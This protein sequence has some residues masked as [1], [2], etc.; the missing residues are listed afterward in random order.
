MNKISKKI[1]SLV[2]MAAFALTLV[3]A[4]AFA[5]DGDSTYTVE[6][7]AY[8]KA[9]VNITLND[10]EK[11]ALESKGN[12]IVWAEDEDGA[13]AYGTEVTFD[14][15]K[16]ASEAQWPSVD[17][18]LLSNVTSDKVSVD[19]TFVGDAPKDANVFVAVN[20]EATIKTFAEAKEAAINTAG[21]PFQNQ[22]AVSVQTSAMNIV[23]SNDEVQTTDTVEVN[24]DLTAKFTLRNSDNQTTIANP[25]AMHVW[26]MEKGQ[27]TDALIVDNAEPTPLP[28]NGGKTWALNNASSL[29]NDD[30]ITLSFSRPG[31]YVVYAGTKAPK[32]ADGTGA[33]KLMASTECTITVNPEATTVENITLNPKSINAAPNSFKPADTVT[34]TVSGVKTGT[35]TPATNFDGKVISIENDNESKGVYVYK[36][37][38]ETAISEATVKDGK[39]TFDVKIMNG[40]VAGTYPVVLTCDDAEVTLYVTVKGDNEATTIEVVDTDSK[41]VNM[42]KPDFTGVAEVIFKDADGNATTAPVINKTFVSAPEGFD[43]AGN[44]MNLSV[45]KIE[46]TDKYAL[47]YNGQ[48]K[49]GD[50]TVRLGIDGQT[51]SNAVVELS[52]TATKVG[53]TVALEIDVNNDAETIVSGGSVSGTVYAV[54][55]NGIKTAV[56]DADVAL[57][58]VNSAAVD[59]TAT[60]VSLTDNG[61]FTVKAKGEEKYYGSKIT[62]I[63]FDKK[64]YVKATKEL[65]VVDGMSTNTLAFDSEEGPIAKNNTVKVSVVDENG[66][67]VSLK[68]GGQAYAYV[69][70]KSNEDAK[71]DV[72]F[73]DNGA[74]GNNGK[75]NLTVYSDKE[76]TADI[77][78]AIQDKDTKAVYANTLTYA[79]GEQDI[80]VDTTVVMTI[81]SADFVVNNEVVT[82]EDSAPYIANDR[83]YVPFRALGEALGAEV[84]WDND[85]RTVTYTLGNTEVVLTI[86]ETTYTVNGE[87]KTMDVAP[88]ITGDRTYV[89][90]RFVGEALGFKVVALSAADGTTASVVFQ[91]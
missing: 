7:S 11:T 41:Y 10:D 35:G 50:Y 39:I 22:G 46:D 9:T 40:A 62:L 23:N 64:T 77:I 37:G 75:I 28:D 68:D 34:A 8:N 91:K 4:A 71:V 88:V 83:T 89:P 67:T 49:A 38:T 51:A 52:F 32:E 72:S 78:V 43:K 14:N 73:T 12:I 24:E 6:R 84:N 54:D 56:D 76:T 36:T 80:P 86:D 25:S 17:A 45:K 48:L 63:A 70:S 19:L 2:T 31:T 59:L 3:P 53:E 18:A 55:A 1:V 15:E 87:E 65:T 90:V 74:V 13:L 5:A 44:A 69:E 42:K 60:D 21:L 20:D 58:F 33:V 61:K 81:G 26:A 30:E 47:A 16:G 57:G 66:K 29:K 82:K 85:A 27:V 79:F